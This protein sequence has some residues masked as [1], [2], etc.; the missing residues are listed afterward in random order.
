M[1][2]LPN[3]TKK[4]SIK[5]KSIAIKTMKMKQVLLENERLKNEN[6][7]LREKNEKLKRYDLGNLNGLT[8]DQLKELQLKMTENVTKVRAKKDSLMED[9]ILCMICFTNKKN[10]VIQGCI[11]ILIFV[12]NVKIVCQARN[13][14]DVKDYFKIL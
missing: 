1:K 12:R 10:I 11:I 2:Y 9:Q 6:N 7:T 5:L 14:H 13:V 3:Y 8:Q 4:V